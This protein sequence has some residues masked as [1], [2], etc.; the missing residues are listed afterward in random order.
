MAGVGGRWRFLFSRSVFPRV[1]KV[2]GLG[3]SLGTPV[4]DGGPPRRP[5]RPGAW[6]L[7][8]AAVMKSSLTRACLDLPVPTAFEVPNPSSKL[9]NSRLG[10]PKA[11][12]TPGPLASG[13]TMVC[14]SFAH[15]EMI[16]W[17]N[18]LGVMRPASRDSLACAGGGQTRGQRR[19]K[20]ESGRL[21]GGRQRRG[22]SQ[23]ASVRQKRGR[24]RVRDRTAPDPRSEGLLV[25]MC[26]PVGSGLTESNENRRAPTSRFCTSWLASTWESKSILHCRGVAVGGARPLAL[27]G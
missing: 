14:G 4:R 26:I 24:R 9:P 8:Q 16:W 10:P 23:R 3:P 5:G 13:S 21:A 19:S 17:V 2:C 27:G 1:W 7:I 20:S 15:I 25:P 12:P 18:I 6:W 22:A 11:D